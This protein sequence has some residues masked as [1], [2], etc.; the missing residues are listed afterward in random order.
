MRNQNVYI[1]DFYFLSLLIALS[2]Q[3]VLMSQYINNILK[4][5][6]MLKKLNKKINID[7]DKYKLIK[8]YLQYLTVIFHSQQIGVSV[9]FLE[10]NLY[11]INE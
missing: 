8:K 7:R 11:L 4:Y 3:S 2:V 5:P 6:N 10:Y 1:Y 9:S